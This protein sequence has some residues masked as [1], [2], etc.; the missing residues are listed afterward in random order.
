MTPE[1]SLIELLERLGAEQGAPV[2]ISDHEL[3]T[4]PDTAVTAMKSQGLLTR[5]RPATSA[6]CPECELECV[7][8]VHTLFEEGHEPL[9]LIFCDKRSDVNRVPIPFSRLEQ[10]QISG[11]SLAHLLAVLLGLH[12][13][14]SVNTN[15]ARWEIGLFKGNKH[16]SHLLLMADGNLTLSLAGHSVALADVL[17]L[18][19]GTF[20]VDKRRL[21]QLVDRPA[22]GGG[23][24]ESATKRRER[25]KKRVQALKKQGVKAFVKTVADEEGISVSRLKQLLQE[26]TEP[27]NPKSIW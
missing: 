12:R 19:G 20:T 8:P 10:W 9:A 14:N 16:S 24:V 15:A 21:K 11:D 2:L 6:I 5:A 22:T 18:D 1:A 23:D 3:N 7:M 17:S 27:K 4:W 26:E 13:S 25:L